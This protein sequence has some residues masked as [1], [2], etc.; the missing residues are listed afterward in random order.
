MVAS[1][2]PAEL[3]GHAPRDGVAGWDDIE[4]GHADSQ[5]RSLARSSSNLISVLGPDGVLRY[6]SPSVERVLGYKRS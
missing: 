5:F 2:A 6:Q 3:S 1:L 4:G